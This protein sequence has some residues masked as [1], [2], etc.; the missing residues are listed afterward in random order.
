[1]PRVARALR[2]PMASGSARAT[3]EGAMPAARPVGAAGPSLGAP[4]AVLAAGRAER[5]AVGLSL[6]VAARV[7]AALRAMTRLPAALSVAEGL[8]VALAVPGGRGAV[9]REFRNGPRRRVALDAGQRGA[10]QPAMEADLVVRRRRHVLRRAGL[11]RAFAR[12]PIGGRGGDG[13]WRRL[14]RRQPAQRRRAGAP[15]ASRTGASAGGTATGFFLRLTGAFPPLYACSPSQVVHLT[16]RMSS[17]TSATMAW[18]LNR[19]SR[20][21]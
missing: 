2:V 17:P 15:P 3:A 8:A 12:D 6:P 14:L 7:E 5:I 16:W 21:Q 20:G 10:D 13:A 11:R 1:M 18:L 19:R 9:H 4:L